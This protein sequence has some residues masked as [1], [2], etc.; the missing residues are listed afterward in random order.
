MGRKK[1]GLAGGSG[2]N[3]NYAKLGVSMSGGTHYAIFG[4]MNQQGAI[5]PGRRPCTSSQNGRGGCSMSLKTTP[6]CRAN[7]PSS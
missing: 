2:P 3:F 5:N 4:D 6:P 1:F 7:W